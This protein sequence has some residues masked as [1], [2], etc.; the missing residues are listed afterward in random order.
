MTGGWENRASSELKLPTMRSRFEPVPTP[1]SAPP[2]VTPVIERRI[3][4]PKGR[5]GQAGGCMVGG[6]VVV[7]VVRQH[8]LARP[9]S[10]V[11]VGLK[12]GLGCG[13]GIRSVLRGVLPEGLAT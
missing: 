4:V 8:I 5:S 3:F 1:L 6:R 11:V 7:V 10:K 9:T 13:C 2:A 12:K